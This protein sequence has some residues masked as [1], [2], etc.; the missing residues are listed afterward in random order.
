[1]IRQLESSGGK[2]VKHRTMASGLHAGQAAMGEYGL[3]PQTVQEF[4]TRRK[5]RG[6]FGPDEALMAQMNPEQLTEF[7]AGQ[8]RVEQG[9]ASDFADLVLKRAKGDEEKAAYMWNTGHNR[10]ISQIDQDRLDKSQYVQRFRK[11]KGILSE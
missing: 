1:M 7:L 9:L 6:Q 2:N 5:R 4:V 3:M 8:D 11:L 10:P